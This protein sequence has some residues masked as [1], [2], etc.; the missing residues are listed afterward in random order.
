MARSM[1]LKVVHRCRQFNFKPCA[2]QCIAVKKSADV[3]VALSRSDGS[4]EIW[5]DSNK[6]WFCR[7]VSLFYLF[8]SNILTKSKSKVYFCCYYYVKL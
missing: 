5:T 4:I 7:Q 1:D 2:I 8:L 6:V 3:L